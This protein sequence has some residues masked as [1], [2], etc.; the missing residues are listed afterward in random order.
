V[1]PNYDQMRSEELA[2]QL[3]AARRELAAMRQRA[4]AAEAENAAMRAKVTTAQQF[5][6]VWRNHAETHE[7]M[8]RETATLR[9][10]EGQEA[11]NQ[12]AE[13]TARAEAAERERYNYKLRAIELDMLAAGL[14]KRVST[15]TEKLLSEMKR[16]EAAEAKLFEESVAFATHIEVIDNYAAY[17]AEATARGD[18]PNTFADW[19]G[20]AWEQNEVQP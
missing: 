16:A 9:E 6:S 8:W 12:I 15:L 11:A 1:T 18:A 20:G 4:E 17:Y 19:F 3:T 5:S 14:E 10:T 2:A 7:R 13:L